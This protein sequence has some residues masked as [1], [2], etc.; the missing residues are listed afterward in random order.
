MSYRGSDIVAL[1]ESVTG[2]APRKNDRGWMAVCPAHKDDYPSLS[3]C[4]GERGVLLNCFQ[5]CTAKEIC[6][7]LNIEL[8]DLF[9]DNN[10]PIKRRSNYSREQFE[11]DTM[12][13]FIHYSEK[14]DGIVASQDEYKSFRRAEERLR[15][16]VKRDRAEKDRTRRRKISGAGRDNHT[17]PKGRK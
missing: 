3:I 7:A 6:N 9:Y 13:C 10:Q 17:M 1:C 5:G 11:I 14:L 12:H 8:K 4:D 2:K 16:Y 15:E